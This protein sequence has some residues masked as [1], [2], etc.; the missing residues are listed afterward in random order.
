MEEVGG[1]YTPVDRTQLELFAQ[2]EGLPTGWPL[3]MFQPT[4]VGSWP[5][6]QG[7]VRCQGPGRA[8]WGTGAD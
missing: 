5:L 3:E 2:L 6:T 8:I 7:G 4:L 1:T